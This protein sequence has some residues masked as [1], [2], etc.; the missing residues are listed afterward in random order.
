MLRMSS[1]RRAYWIVLCLKGGV[2]YWSML[3]VSRGMMGYWNMLYV[4]SGIVGC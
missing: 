1:G 4:S 2:G 3:Y